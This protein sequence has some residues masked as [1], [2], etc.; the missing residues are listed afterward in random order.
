LYALLDVPTL[1][2][3]GVTGY[4]FEGWTG[5]AAPAATPAAVIARL[6]AEIVRI[7]DTTEARDWF[8]ASGADPGLLTP[9]AFAQFIRAEHDKLGKVIREAGIKAE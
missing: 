6:H 7:A 3:A 8:A 1:A 4:E 9:E 5:V 2:E